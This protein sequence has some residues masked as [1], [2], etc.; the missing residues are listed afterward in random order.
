MSSEN[1]K[2]I[3]LTSSGTYRLMNICWL[4]FRTLVRNFSLARPID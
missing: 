3:E 1:L 4:K 2:N